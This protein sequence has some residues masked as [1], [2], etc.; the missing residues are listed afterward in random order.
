MDEIQC[1][2]CQDSHPSDHY[3]EIKCGHSF[4]EDCLSGKL[5]PHIVINKCPLCSTHIDKA[6]EWR[7]TNQDSSSLLTDRLERWEVE[8][9]EDVIVLQPRPV[10]RR[11]TVIDFSLILP[12]LNRLQKLEKQVNINIEIFRKFCKIPIENLW[13]DIRSQKKYKLEQIRNLDFGESTKWW[14]FETIFQ[15]IL[16]EIQE[17]ADWTMTITPEKMGYFEE[18]IEDIKQ[19]ILTNDKNI[20][21]IINFLPNNKRNIA[22]TFIN[23]HNGLKSINMKHSPSQYVEYIHEPYFCDIYKVKSSITFSIYG[24]ESKKWLIR[25]MEKYIQKEYNTIVTKI[26]NTKK[27]KRENKYKMLK[28]K[29]ASE[30]FKAD[31]CE[32]VFDCLKALKEPDPPS[33]RE[34]G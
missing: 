13:K 24:Y 25:D 22:V 30:K 26:R 5:S 12:L 16:Y 3:F 15:I 31:G 27:W 34:I 7:S 23:K 1:V 10:V 2:V 17:L 32:G 33:A 11:T 8:D 4:H 19:L 14:N 20:G 28:I 18:D 6:E 29:R 9:V 21:N